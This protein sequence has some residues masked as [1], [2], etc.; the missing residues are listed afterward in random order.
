MQWGVN[1]SMTSKLTFFQ[2]ILKKTAQIIYPN[3]CLQ[4]GA[5]GEN[6]IDLCQR[7]YQS[8]PWIKFYCQK[9]AL[10]LTSSDAKICGACNKKN[11]Y[12]DQTV[13]PFQFEGFIRDAVYQFKF[14]QKL[15]Q[16]KLLARLFIRS[17]ENREYTVPDIIIPVPL[18]KKRLRKRG[19]NQALEIARI[20]S[21]KLNCDLSYKDI[22]RNRDTGVQM[23]LPAK[24]RYKN[25]KNAF[26]LTK[27]SIDF[28]NKHVC[29]ID[30][31]MTTGNTVNEAAKCLK[32]AGAKKVDVWCIARVA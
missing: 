31:V 27:S 32:K 21:K 29:I 18:H 10:P 1:K 20:I 12:F 17:I 22:Y 11:Y 26:S 25:V 14:K 28:K 13:A 7:C 8:L 5:E 19:Y 30:D 3:V 15:N 2:L 9:C 23:E 24:Q 16:G 6:R 4:C